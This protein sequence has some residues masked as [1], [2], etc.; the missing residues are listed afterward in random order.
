MKKFV[1]ALLAMIVLLSGC[2]QSTPVPIN[3]NIN[4]TPS[5]TPTNTAPPLPSATPTASITPLPTIPT[6]TPTFDASTIVTVTPASKAECPKEVTTTIDFLI[7]KLLDERSVSSPNLINDSKVLDYLNNGGS[8]SVLL[9]ELQN[10]FMSDMYKYQDI[11]GDGVNDLSIAYRLGFEYRDV[12]IYVCANGKYQSFSAINDN[13]E[14]LKNSTIILAIKDLNGNDI[15]EI[16]ISDTPILIILEWQGSSFNRYTLRAPSSMKSPGEIKDLNNDGLDEIIFIGK[17]TRVYRLG[18]DENIYTGA[19]W[20]DE[21]IVYSWDGS[22][23][24]KQSSNYLSAEYRFQAIQDADQFTIQ[25]NYK[26]ALMLYQNA[27][28]EDKLLSWSPEMHAYELDILEARKND[29][30]TPTPPPPDSTEYPRLAAYAY[31]RI[32]LL[33]LAQGQ[34]SDATA[35]YNTLQQIFGNDPYAHPYVEMASAFWEA[36][37]STH[38]MYD[39]CAAAIQYVVEHP[40]ILIPLGSDYHGWQAKVYKP[41]DVCPFR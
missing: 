8:L 23:Y 26:Q 35:T 6:F 24:S 20:R 25:E 41:A 7:P 19:P 22:A 13:W 1:F 21:I 15:P 31:Y 33:H 14:P 32:M 27:I 37:Q 12:R 18:F 2:G 38:K 36:Y 9:A 34:E 30:I 40:E 3:E 11:T 28:L 39:G 5:L 17:E 4:S 29:Q 16:V 10:S